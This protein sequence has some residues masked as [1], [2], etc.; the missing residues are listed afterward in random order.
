MLDIDKKQ[1][2]KLCRRKRYLIQ[3]AIADYFFETMER[4][5]G[6]VWLESSTISV[7]MQRKGYV[8]G[9]GK[10]SDH[11]RD[12]A[13]RDVLVKSPITLQWAMNKKLVRNCEHAAELLRIRP[14]RTRSWYK[15][16]KEFIS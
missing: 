7:D 14:A 5:P 15:R 4:Y 3:V 11:L 8:F 2:S 6:V 13:S 12:M 16:W 1:T 9:A 10:L